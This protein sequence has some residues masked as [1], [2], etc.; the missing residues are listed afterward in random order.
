MTFQSFFKATMSEICLLQLLEYKDL[1]LF[2][3]I[4]NSKWRDFVFVTTGLTAEAI[5]RHYFGLWNFDEPC[6]SFCFFIQWIN[7]GKI[8]RLINNNYLKKYVSCSPNVKPK[9]SENSQT[10]SESFKKFSGANCPSYD[11]T[12]RKQWP[13]YLNDAVSIFQSW[14]GGGQSPGII[15]M[16]PTGCPEEEVSAELYTS[17]QG[18]G[19]A[20][21]GSLH[22]CFS[23]FLVS[24]ES[25]WNVGL[26]PQPR[27]PWPF[28]CSS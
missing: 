26:T 22:H 4:H 16:R 28:C 5:W 13:L 1:V 12:V 9:F 14:Q 17:I 11:L 19:G 21:Q 27:M 20:R 18:Q 24:L 15:V 25:P 2:L 8:C 3:V 6:T 7:C 10:S 23:S